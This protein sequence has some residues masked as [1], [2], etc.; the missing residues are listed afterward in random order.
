MTAPGIAFARVL[1]ACGLGMGLGIWYGF[2]RPLRQKHTFLG[3]SLFVLALL[4]VWVVQD[5]FGRK[6]NGGKVLILVTFL[7]HMFLLLLH[8]TFGGYQFG[9][10]YAVDLI[11]YA[12]FYQ[13]MR[14]EKHHVPVWQWCVL[15][16]GFIFTF[17]G[18]LWIHL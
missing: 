18:S 17:L 15:I 2:L 4:P 6:L 16:A 5:L 1:W 3:D 11:P 9:A 12:F 8:R 14:S 10:R 7:V 13:L